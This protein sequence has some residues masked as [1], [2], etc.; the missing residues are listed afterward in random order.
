[1]SNPQNA[2][3]PI[4]SEALLALGAHIAEQTIYFPVDDYVHGVKTEIKYFGGCIYVGE[5][6]YPH[7]ESIGDFE[8]L[9]RILTGRE[10]EVK[11]ASLGNAPFLYWDTDI[12]EGE[13]PK[14]RFADDVNKD[15]KFVYPAIPAN[16]LPDDLVRFLDRY[17]E[18]RNNHSFVGVHDSLYKITCDTLGEFASRDLLWAIAERGGLDEMVNYP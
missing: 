14:I 18:A 5:Q 1:M 12:E 15:S 2:N 7:C 16:T 10:L 4:T 3:A 13:V 8:L 6:K 11:S 9:Y 17:C